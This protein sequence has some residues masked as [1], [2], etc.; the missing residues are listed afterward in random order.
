[1]PSSQVGNPGE[2]G[3]RGPEGNRGQPGIEGPPGT[4]G[5]RGVQGDRGAPGVR[6]TQGPP[7]RPKNTKFLEFLYTRL[8]PFT[9]TISR[10]HLTLS[11][12]SGFDFCKFSSIRVFTF[13]TCST[14]M[15][16]KQRRKKKNCQC[17]T[18]SC[19]CQPAV[20]SMRTVETSPSRETN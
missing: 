2:A 6:G 7:V 14:N 8:D 16:T 17:H 4:A 9:A 15:S 12:V 10:Y 1:M 20:V 18:E 3:T 5:P 11:Y 19:V 13:E